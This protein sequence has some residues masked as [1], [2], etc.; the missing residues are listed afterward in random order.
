[1]AACA[2]SSVSNSTVPK[3][4]ERPDWRSV[5]MSA[6]TAPPLSLAMSAAEAAQKVG[7]VQ[8]KW[9]VHLLATKTQEEKQFLTL[10][11]GERHAKVSDVDGRGLRQDA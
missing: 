7:S 8:Q 11:H 10:Q 1:M 9:H 4:R 2:A 3:P 5:E 6:F